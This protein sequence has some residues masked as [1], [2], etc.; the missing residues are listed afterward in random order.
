MHTVITQYCTGCKLCLPPCP[1]DCIELEPNI[2][3]QE[4]NEDLSSGELRE[5]KNKFAAFS[6]KN[7]KHH[8]LRLEKIKQEKQAS[9]ERKK[10][11]LLNR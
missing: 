10:R 6:R 2:H 9:F 11:E 3:F 5:L 4:L 1:V 8:S 7:K